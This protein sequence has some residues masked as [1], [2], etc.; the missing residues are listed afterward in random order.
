M[1]RKSIAWILEFASKL[2]TE[3][4]KIKCLRANNVKPILTVLQFCYHPGIKWGLPEGEPPYIASE[5]ATVDDF[6]DEV[7]RLY[8]FIEGAGPGMTDSRR[9]LLFT[10]M[11][12]NITSKD[13][14]L[15]VSIKDK[16]LPYPGLDAAI[17]RK[18]FPDLF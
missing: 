3:D 18:A 17:V 11:L 16:K 6:Y 1:K 15:L 5:E 10:Q 14:E 9:Q 8:I 4:E 7:K 12:G 2:P 13:A